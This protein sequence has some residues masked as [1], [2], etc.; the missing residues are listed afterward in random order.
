MTEPAVDPDYLALIQSDRVSPHTRAALTSRAEPIG[1]DYRPVMLTAE[2]L[3]TLRAV[4]ARVLP[5][6]GPDTIDL[7]ARMD[8]ALAT[9]TGDGWRFADLPPDPEAC[10]SGLAA[11]DSASRAAHGLGFTHLLAADQESVLAWAASGDGVT[12]GGWTGRQ[13][14]RWF[15]DLRA[16]AVKLYVAH[17]ATMAR[18]GYSGIAYG[19]DGDRLQG[20]QA[21]EPGAH[22]PWEPVA[23]ADRPA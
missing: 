22:A 4:L 19:G 21:L 20:F 16:E 23:A 14:Q 15:E 6:H 13:M 11:I 3:A 12:V 7:G 2:E 8:T 1:P 10:R 17:P 9:G 18:I 5:Q